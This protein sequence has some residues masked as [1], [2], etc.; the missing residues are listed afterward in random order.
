MHDCSSVVPGI[1]LHLWWPCLA[2][3][4]HVLHVHDPGQVELLLTL[5][6]YC[7]EERDH[8]AHGHCFEAVFQQVRDYN[9]KGMSC[10]HRI[11]SSRSTDVECH[12]S[13]CAHLVLIADIFNLSRMKPV[14]HAGNVLV[15]MMTL[16]DLLSKCIF[17]QANE[18]L[19]N[20][21]VGPG[22]S[23][24]YV[25]MDRLMNCRDSYRLACI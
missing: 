21:A 1:K 3:L 19:C 25:R 18:A 2:S 24:K 10:L 4:H 12:V 23:Y 15:L 11:S 9:H 17:C 16:S 20:W 6:E 8:T 13:S 7:E 22:C 5:E 14:C